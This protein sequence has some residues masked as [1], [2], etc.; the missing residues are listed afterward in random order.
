ML[1]MRKMNIGTKG[2]QTAWAMRPTPICAVCLITCPKPN[3]SLQ[4]AHRAFHR[5]WPCRG[6]YLVLILCLTS[7]SGFPRRPV[8]RLR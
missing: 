5:W 4:R 6:T 3:G 7:T 1:C 2:I 8:R